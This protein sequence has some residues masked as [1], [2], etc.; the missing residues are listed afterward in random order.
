MINSARYYPSLIS[1]I[2]YGGLKFLPEFSLLKESL[3]LI[4]DIKFCNIIINCQNL[5]VIRHEK[6]AQTFTSSANTSAQALNWLTDSDLGAGVLNRFGASMVSFVLNLFEDKRVT[7][8]F[9]TLRTFIEDLNNTN[10][11]L[12]ASPDDYP[13]KITRKITS[14]DHCSFQMCLEPSSIIVNVVIN[15]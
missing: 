13:E 6:S 12:K 15:R 11:S 7:K 2:S 5:A 1:S 10:V 14:D 8:V 9:G 4:G 3:P